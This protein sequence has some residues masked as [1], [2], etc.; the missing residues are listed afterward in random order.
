MYTQR[1]IHF[2]ALGKDPELRAALE[3]RNASGNALA[4]HALGQLM[5]SPA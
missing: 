4:P 5:F 3:E 2:P 1:I